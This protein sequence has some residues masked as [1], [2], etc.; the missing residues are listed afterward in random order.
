MS[1]S[2]HPSNIIKALPDNIS[3]RIYNISSEK[4]TFNNAAPFYNNVLS[5]SGYK[6][7]FTYQQDLTPSKK[8]RQRKKVLLNPTYSVNRGNKH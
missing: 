1:I 4:A 2:N 7:N 3:K 8:V 5:V 6:E